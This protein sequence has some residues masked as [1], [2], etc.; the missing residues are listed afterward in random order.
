[1]FISFL[2]GVFVQGVFGKGGFCLG[3][4]CPDT[5]YDPNK[6]HEGA[7]TDGDSNAPQNVLPAG[8]IESLSSPLESPSVLTFP[9]DQH[10]STYSPPTVTPCQSRYSPGKRSTPLTSFHATSQALKRHTTHD[11]NGTH[12]KKMQKFN[13][14]SQETE[15]HFACSTLMIPNPVLPQQEDQTQTVNNFTTKNSSRIRK[16]KVIFTPN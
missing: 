1:M 8:E 12:M 11:Q 6:H 16:P 9:Q 7:Q 10:E 15:H 13:Q 14:V 3:G 5:G 2:W 4:F